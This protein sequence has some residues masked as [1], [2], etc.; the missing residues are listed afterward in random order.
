MA[1][2]QKSC[3]GCSG[4]SIFHNLRIQVGNKNRPNIDT[5]RSPRRNAAWHRLS[6]DLGRFRCA[7]LV[8]K[9][10]K[11][12]CRK[13]SKIVMLLGKGRGRPERKGVYPLP[14]SGNTKSDP[15]PSKTMLAVPSQKHPRAI[16][17]LPKS[18]WDHLQSDPNRFSNDFRC[19]NASLEPKKSSK[20]H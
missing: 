16:Q 13:T 3:S 14:S 17:E 18:N 19:E 7:S 5:K 12:R 15:K 4:G 11:K 9:T 10:I 8:G 1:T 20:F 6:L 2:S